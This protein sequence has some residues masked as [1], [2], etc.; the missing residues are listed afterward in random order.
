[1]KIST[2]LALSLGSALLVAGAFSFTAVS[3][4]PAVQPASSKLAVQPKS[5]VST[6][7]TM[8]LRG[9]L[10]ILTEVSGQLVGAAAN[11][12]DFVDGALKVSRSIATDVERPSIA[13]HGADAL[14]LGDLG[15]RS[16][17]LVELASGKIS[18][19]LRLDEVRDPSAESIPSGDTLRSG[20]FRSVASDGQ[21]LYVA[22]GAGF[23]SAIFKI[24]PKSKTIVS[25]S[26][27]NAEDP[28]AMVVHDGGLFVAT[29][30]GATIRRFSLTLERSLESIEL[31]ATTG[32]GLAI[33]G[34]EIM[35]LNPDLKSVKVQAVDQSKVQSKSIIDRLD[36]VRILPQ[37]YT[38]I[39]IP[40]LNLRKRYAVLI[41]G[42]LAENFSGECFWNDTVWMY[43]ALLANG[44][45]DADIIVLYGDG[46][47]YAS[48]NAAYRHPTTVTD[49][50]ATTANVNMVL[51][52]LKNGD[53]A[54]GIPKMDD[55]DTLFVWTFD[56]GGLSG[57][58]STLCLR[59]G[60][61]NANSFAT[62]LNAIAYESRA[63]FMQQCYS[64]G[65]INPLKN[66]KTF[67]S[68]AS[69]ADEVARPA[70]TENEMVG[71]RTYSHGEFN[72]HII[73]ALNRLHTTPPGGVV[74]ADSNADSWISSL[75][76]HNWN[77]ARES[78]PETPQVNDMGGIGTIFRFKK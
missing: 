24:D 61:I 32:K 74:N 63:I 22:M 75:E 65:F 10:Q 78:R 1:M 41:T 23:S 6:Q 69:R 26:W 9:E 12:I 67:I 71:G 77:V 25:R 62:K 19:W 49:F 56:H 15:K 70:D 2:S 72:Y 60:V 46:V 11:R 29:Q 7:P 43:K 35:M 66:A 39:R 76:M 51:D 47:D 21:S 5:K 31:G 42:D 73:T 37:R 34:S 48:A 28:D 64:G 36:K 17:S 14:V 20:E 44:Y 8:K 55:N 4:P 57:G 52:G 40:A 38:K 30:R 53:A 27:A 58:V 54:R 13:P 33:R 3:A 45:T 16:V 50:A 68:T 59:D 18:P